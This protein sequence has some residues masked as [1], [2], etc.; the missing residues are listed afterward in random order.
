LKIAHVAS[1]EPE[2]S[3]CNVFLVDLSELK[4]KHALHLEELDVARVEIVELQ[5][6]SSLLGA[7]TSCPVLHAKLDEVVARASSLKAALKSPIATA[8]SSCCEKS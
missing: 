7:C 2:C 6:R 1:D 4:S 3:D 8:C 5:S